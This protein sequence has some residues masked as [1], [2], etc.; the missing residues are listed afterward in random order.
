MR[1]IPVPDRLHPDTV[2]GHHYD[3]FAIGLTDHPLMNQK[4]FESCAL[5]DFPTPKTSSIVEVTARLARGT[6]SSDGTAM[7]YYAVQ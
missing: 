3:I 6:R 2:D 7:Y 4:D 1:V 5:V